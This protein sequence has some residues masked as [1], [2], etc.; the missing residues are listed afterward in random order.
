MIGGCDRRGSWLSKR[1][2][3]RQGACG[4]CEGSPGG[5]RGFVLYHM[6]PCPVGQQ[7]RWVNNSTVI[8]ILDK[9]WEGGQG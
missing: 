4:G 7:G 6:C 1:R 3:S 9:G 8:R 2:E 5:G